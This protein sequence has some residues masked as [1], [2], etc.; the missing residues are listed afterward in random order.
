MP[1]A[2]KPHVYKMDPNNSNKA[3]IDHEA[4]EIVKIMEAYGSP[5]V[6]YMG[7]M[8]KYFKDMDCTNPYTDEEIQALEL[9]IPAEIKAARDKL[10]KKQ[11]ETDP[12]KL[13]FDA[14]VRA[15]LPGPLKNPKHIREQLV[16]EQE[17][18]KEKRM[19]ARLNRQTLGRS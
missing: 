16:G 15:T 11:M 10:I 9:P 12:T 1:T 5:K 13:N 19:I 18:F 4:S 2:R 8:N 17:D 6:I 7:K 14:I 3:M